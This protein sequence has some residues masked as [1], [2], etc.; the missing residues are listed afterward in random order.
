MDFEHSTIQRQR[1]TLRDSEYIGDM[2]ILGERDW[3]SSTCFHFP[4]VSE[5]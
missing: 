1:M 3:A 5:A 4:P 2:A